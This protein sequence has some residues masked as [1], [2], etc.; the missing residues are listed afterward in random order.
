MTRRRRSDSPP[1]WSPTRRAGSLARLG[2]LGILLVSVPSITA[3]QENPGGTIPFEEVTVGMTGH[4]RTVFSGSTVESFDAEVI[5]KLT[6]IAPGKNVIL[7]RLSGGPLA[8]TGVIQG[9]SGSP[10]YLDGR[11]AGAVAYSWGFSREPIC[12]LTPIGEMLDLLSRDAEPQRSAAASP[13]RGRPASINLLVKP[14]VITAFLEERFIQAVGR[15]SLQGLTP[16]PIPVT[17]SGGPRRGMAGGDLRRWEDL[18][19]RAG[20]NPVTAGTVGAGTGDGAPF[21]PGSAMGVQL[22]RGDV[23]FSVIG[24]IT[25]VR[26]SQFL[27]MGHNFLSLGPTALPATRA[28][29]F[30]ILPSLASSFKLAGPTGTAGLITQDRFGGLSGSLSGSAP[31]VPVTVNLRS[32]SE[33]LST[34]TYEIV[35][36]PLLTPILMH[37][38]FLQIFTTAEKVAGEITLSVRK[39][40][41]IRMEDGLD[42]NLENL[43]SGEQSELIA[44]A[45]VAYMTYLLMNNPDRASRVEGVDLDLEYADKLSLAR[46]DRIWTDRYTA[47]PGETL[48]LYVKVQPYR[49]E[50][51]VE[52]IPLEIPD[53]AAEG[54]VLLQV[55]DAITLSR[56]EYETGGLS[57]QP[58][59]LEQLV[60]LLNRIRSNNKIYATI[61][62]PDNGIYVSGE[63]L[64]NLPPSLSTLLFSPKREES[65]AVRMKLRGLL[66]AERETRY[67][68]RGYQKAVVEIKR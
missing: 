7:V 55:G 12:G 45:T 3:A 62:R 32:G 65:G 39:G 14:S 61:I 40:S 49:E 52:V 51:F 20:L 34:F 37:L 13:G 22:I 41:R 26:G 57:I 9:M 50:A 36:D 4:G 66:E 30:G 21:E 68:L 48:P 38:S 1:A 54:K 8:E 15:P 63:R 53:E 64:P 28:Q 16:I 2:L 23:D 43:Y 27:A 17:F 56:M 11:L 24:T 35:D 33:R 18:L 46:I 47:A 59:N 5:G 31:V 58:K 44:S 29:V 19:S 42:V 6:N 10:V 25:Y 60:Y 67:A